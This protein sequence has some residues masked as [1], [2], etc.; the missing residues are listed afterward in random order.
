MSGGLDSGSERRQ[1]TRAA[2]I[3]SSMT[4]ASRILGYARDMVFAYLFGTTMAADAFIAAFRIPNLLRRLFGEGSLSIAFVPV[5]TDYLSSGD[6]EEAMRFARSIFYLLGLVLLVVACLGIAASDWIVRF[7]AYGFTADP[8]KF[9]L[10]VKLTRIMLPYICFIGLVALSMGILNSL[11]HFAAPAAA[12]VMLNLAMIAS[13]VVFAWASD[14]VQVRITGLAI[15]VLAGGVAQ[16]GLQLPFLVKHRV[17]IGR[18]APLFHPGLRKIVALMGPAV[19]GA[20]VYQINIVV[21]TQLASLLAQ[22]SV[23]YLYYADRIVQFPLGIFAIAT[24]TAVLPSLSQQAA[25]NDLEAMKD[26]FGHGLRLVFFAVLPSLVGLL[27]LREPIVAVLFR[28]GVFDLEST[29]K[30]AQALFYYALGLWAFSAVRI[31]LNFFYALQDTRTPVKAASISIVANIVL[32]LALMGPMGHG[33]LA[34]ATSLASM[35]NLVLLVLWLRRKLG[36]LGGLGLLR[37]LS[38]SAACAIVMGVVVMVVATI[39]SPL[40]ASGRMGLAMRLM[41]CIITGVGVYCGLA[42]LLNLEEL[43]AMAET[44]LRRKGPGR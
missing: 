2:G 38:K 16:L 8:L 37:D 44:F 14:S 26:T 24:A 22:G 29:H 39:W 32:G 4:L 12:P 19:F 3:V 5:F 9:A 33:G 40:E 11:G 23:A 13:A 43:R 1:V 28:H 21:N 6:R 27:V 36:P 17:A 7:M 34:L 31:L 30:T 18:P 15:G 25:R 10:A 42:Y 20:A 35:V 41:G